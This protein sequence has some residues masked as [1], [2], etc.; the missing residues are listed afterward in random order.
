[1][2]VVGVLIAVALAL[3]LQTTLARL[4][5]SGTGAIDL[6]LVAVVAVA[7]TTGP[8]SGMLAGSAAGL[9]Q[10]S[11]STGVLG[12]GGLAKSVIGFLAGAI[13]QQFIL[14]SAPARFLMFVGATV[15]HAALFMGLNMLLGL[16]TFPTPWKAV[17]S[18][19]LGNAVIGMIAFAL[20]E[21]IPGVIERRRAGR[22]PRG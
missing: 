21:A 3:A 22:R 12:I 16:R 9:I 4:V 17:G 8:V 14:T 13:S 7:L 2:K 11:L 10:D 18:Q 19:A 6:V 5:V 20:T 15:L 1:V